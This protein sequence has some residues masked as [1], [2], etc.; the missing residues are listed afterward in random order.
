MSQLYFVE[1]EKLEKLIIQGKT[2]LDGFY[3]TLIDTNIAYHLTPA[4]RILCCESNP[5]DPLKLTNRFIPLSTLQTTGA[6][7]YLNS[8]VLQT[9][10]YL[11][12]QGYICS[13]HDTGRQSDSEL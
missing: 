5:L 12:D 6:D 9:H 3:L 2:R 10:S 8:I 13:L 7:I 11:V 1:Q 4:V